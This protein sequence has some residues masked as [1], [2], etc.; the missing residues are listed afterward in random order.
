MMMKDDRRSG[1]RGVMNDEKTT[2][3]GCVKRVAEMTI[4]RCKDDAKRDVSTEVE[5]ASVHLRAG[6]DL[7]CLSCIQRVL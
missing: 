3:K 2:T 6:C 5:R 7:C 1:S 4:V